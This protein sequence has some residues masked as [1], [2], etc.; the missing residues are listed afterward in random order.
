MI[1][2]NHATTVHRCRFIDYTP[3]NITALS[4]S[5]TSTTKLTPSDLRL[6][7]GRSN[8]DIEIWNPR[9]N[10]CQELVVQGG[11]DRSIEGL[12]WCNIPG[13]PLRLFSI[14]GSTVVTEWDLTTG[15]P[16]KNYDC[17]SGVIWSLA[18]NGSQDKLAVG[19]DNGSV[20]IIDI[21]G[22]KGV[23]EHEVILTRQE[24]RVLTLTWN[25]DDFV[26]G[27]CAD[28]RIR[29]WCTRK[30]DEN[31][32]RLVHT[33]KVDKSK[34]ES[35]LVWCVL[36]LPETNQI[37][38]GDSTGSIKFWDFHYAT[39]I[40]SFKAHE[41]D[42]LCLSTDINNGSVFSAGVDRKIFQFSNVQTGKTKKWVNTSNRLFH[43]NDIRT[44]ASYQSK[45]ADFLVSGG[46]EK[47]L[48]ISSLTSFS[49]GNYKKLPLVVPFKKN[50]LVNK[51]QRL[52]LMW[53]ESTV[54]IWVI[55]TETDNEKNYRLVCKLTLKDEQNISSCALSPDG[56]VLIVGRPSTTK[57]FHLQPMDTR[58]K[59]T[60]LDNEFLLKTGCK[61]VK[62]TSESAIVMVSSNDN[63]FSLDLE[64]DDDEKPDEFELPDIQQTKTSVKLPYINMVNHLEVRDHYAVVGRACGAVDLL[65][66]NN[67]TTKPLIRL[68]NYITAINFTE[69]ATVV[70]VTA[71][72]KVYEFNLEG[73]EDL[74]TS[75]CKKN[76]ESLPVQFQNLKDKCLGIFSD[77]SNKDKVWFWGS[78][79]LANFD[80]S[81]DLPISKRKKPKK[82]SRNGLTITDESNFINDGDEE[83]E[84]E[85]LD[86][87]DEFLIKTLLERPS[88][89][90][91]VKKDGKPFFF[92]D[93]Y[94]PILLADKISENELVI[95]ERPAFLVSSQPAF[96]LPKL[97]F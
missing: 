21:S 79:W 1:H 76:S 71:E 64:A 4:F 61:Y 72:N 54:K 83:E 60:K 82:H 55:G 93:K 19:C 70:L 18:I 16:L 95:V 46:V 26:I 59:V 78:T 35:T 5:H 97:R 88:E 85:D 94:R 36:Y 81:L 86:V 12:V 43:S 73:E 34:K 96:N 40:Q 51:E 30:D 22:G 50:V 84:E 3:G 58:M 90:A 9:D 53:Q 15:L 6:A 47:T 49:D 31:R 25:K 42:V 38:S 92:T 28:G 44:I 66:L 13:E 52:V 23:L 37:V 14:G 62:F 24:S 65:D 20:V 29:V 48:V 32:G 10:W 69:R 68:M 87:P 57:V 39:L 11:K 75:W 41:A 33:M 8:G 2:E 67:H 27:G 7:L 80:M 45:G 74:L 17:N 77:E 56:Q 63:V 89:D 91:R